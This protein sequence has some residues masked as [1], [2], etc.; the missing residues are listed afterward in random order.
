MASV[1]WHFFKQ[2]RAEGC[3]RPFTG[4][5]GYADG[6]QRRDFISVED[7]VKVNMH[8]LDHPDASGIFNTGT[9]RAQR[10]NDVA[11]AVVNAC[12]AADGKP[13]MDLTGLHREGLILYNPF[14]E[15]LVG[16][17][18]HFTE[19]DVGALKGAGYDQPFMAVEQGVQR[20]VEHLLKSA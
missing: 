7:V 20:Y 1:A 5:G 4:S 13:A 19:A 8:F 6:E 10:F 16:K 18:Q 2:Y 17:Y 9:G 3:V 11:C 15:D 14:P 12:R